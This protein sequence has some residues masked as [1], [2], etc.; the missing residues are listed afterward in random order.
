MNTCVVEPKI[1]LM[2]SMLPSPQH[3]HASRLC[4]YHGLA[5][6]SSHDDS[7][8]NHGESARCLLQV[9]NRKVLLKYAY[10][11][12]EMYLG[13][14]ICK[15]SK[16]VTFEASAPHRG[17]CACP[18]PGYAETPFQAPSIMRA[19]SCRFESVCCS[20]GCVTT[21]LR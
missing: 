11:S 9:S 8:L 1:Q 7:Y 3:L 12:P 15:A 17:P 21:R 14:T 16:L 5:E 4:N 19:A 18:L 13:V 20:R 6:T 10:A 2:P